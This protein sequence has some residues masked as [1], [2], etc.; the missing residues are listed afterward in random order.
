MRPY[1]YR[2]LHPAGALPRDLA[3]L[4]VAA[5]EARDDLDDQE[6]DSRRRCS[7]GDPRQRHAIARLDVSLP[8]LTVSFEA[9]DTDAA[10]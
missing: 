9:N 7:A 6:L 2:C 4:S 5:G 10:A 1:C 3:H 8:Y